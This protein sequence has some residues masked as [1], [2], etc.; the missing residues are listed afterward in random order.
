MYLVQMKNKTKQNWRDIVHFSKSHRQL[1]IKIEFYP[2]SCPRKQ[3]FNPL[4]VQRLY[5]EKQW[6]KIHGNKIKI[7]KRHESKQTIS[8]M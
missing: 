5:L 3:T 6:Q 2:N 1:V 4:S 7:F 8:K